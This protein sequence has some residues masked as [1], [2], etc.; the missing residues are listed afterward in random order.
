MPPS[1]RPRWQ[2]AR[3]R[4]PSPGRQ[5]AR[6]GQVPPC[7]RAKDSDPALRGEPAVPPNP[8]GVPPEGQRQPRAD[9]PTAARSPATGN[10]SAAQPEVG[11]SRAGPAS[12]GARGRQP[13]VRALLFRAL[14]FR[15][16]W[17]WPCRLSWCRLSWC[18]L[19]WCPPRGHAP[20][21]MRR[22]WPPEWSSERRPGAGRRA[23]GRPEREPGQEG[24]PPAEQCR[25]SKRWG[26]EP[27]GP[28]RWDPERRRPGLPGLPGRAGGQEG[29]A[30]ERL[31][32]GWSLLRVRARRE[33]P[34][35]WRAVPRRCLEPERRCRV[36][37]LP[38][39]D[40]GLERRPPPSWPPGPDP[41]RETR[42]L[43]QGRGGGGRRRPCRRRQPRARRSRR[44]AR[45]PRTCH[46]PARLLRRVSATR[47]PR[48]RSRA[49][50]GGCGPRGRPPLLEP[51][52]HPP[53]FR[54]S[55]RMPSG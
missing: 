9:P 45:G 24:P 40:S 38:Q 26:P 10:P 49:R 35:Q 51:W 2:S 43:R 30:P 19:S 22:R 15:P 42:G 1:R 6:Q 48:R 28:K 17:L 47:H 36:Q 54:K 32:A 5:E 20:A 27:R 29:S 53:R 13:T 3:C 52:T 4:T 8:H 31:P 25:G 44:Q 21:G 7:R 34:D 37:C 55:G 11:M 46:P 23:A 16:R 50:G 14:M 12:R 39:K 33:P 18:R 41:C